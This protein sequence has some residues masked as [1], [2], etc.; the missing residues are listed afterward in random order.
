MHAKPVRGW[1]RR[2]GVGIVGEMALPQLMIKNWPLKY[3]TILSIEPL[4]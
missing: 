1:K 3:I 4:V 2:N